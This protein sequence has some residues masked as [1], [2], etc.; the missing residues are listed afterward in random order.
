MPTPPGSVAPAA[1]RAQRPV[2]A[3][4]APQPP[5][6]RTGRVISNP[7]ITRQLE[8]LI[9]YTELTDAELPDLLFRLAETYA[10]TAEYW[11]YRAIRAREQ[12]K[13]AGKQDV[14]AKD[15]QRKA[16]ETYERL[17]TEKTFA[18]YARMDEVLYFYAFELQSGGAGQRARAVSQRLIADHP[19]SKYVPDA[20][21]A[22]A[23][24]FF[25]NNNLANAER[26]YDRVLAY[27]QARVHAYAQYKQGWVYLNLGRSADA[28]DA[29]FKVNRSAGVKKEALARAARN[30]FVRAYA[31]VGKPQA[32]Y[33]AFKRL[34]ANDA[35][36]LLDRLARL[37]ADQGKYGDS[38]SVYRS[39]IKRAP[40]DPLVCDWQLGVADAALYIGRRS[41]MVAE[42][43]GAAAIASKLGETACH[44]EVRTR[45]G[46]LARVLHREGISAHGDAPLG[47]ADTLYG[48]YETHFPSAPDLSETRYYHAELLWTRA[49]RTSSTK[50]AHGL[51][52][53]A[54]ALFDEVESDT[55]ATRAHRDEARDAAGKARANAAALGQV[56]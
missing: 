28:L 29:F 39:L 50:A 49:S 30:D 40:T 16:L 31:D 52:L 26:Y 44:E 51:W 22:F 14:Q 41:Q 47:H 38:M 6:A 11:R 25:N 27:P 56:E 21:L 18:K 15:A 17:A 5:S 53:R 37:Y 45:I 35:M 19:Q 13:P 42:L 7:R 23:E 46:Q 54:A 33:Q 48:T 9:Q 4:T 32:A 43:T 3:K 20:L 8:Q 2:A 1:R 36:R 12:G 24:H 55:A 34:D 10:Q